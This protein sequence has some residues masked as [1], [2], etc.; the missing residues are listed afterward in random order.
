M[1]AGA[2]GLDMIGTQWV[3]FL[4]CLPTCSVW[5]AASLKEVCMEA[6]IGLSRK[7]GAI[8][9]AMYSRPAWDDV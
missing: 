5:S 2:L 1:S 4:G 9:R 6:D 8:A 3:S 7:A